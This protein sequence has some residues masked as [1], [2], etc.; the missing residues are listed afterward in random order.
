MCEFLC[1]CTFSFPLGINPGVE[2]L[3]HFVALNLIKPPDCAPK[4]RHNSSFPFVMHK[5]SGF[6][7]SLPTF[8]VF[9]LVVSSIPSFNLK[10]CIYILNV[11]AFCVLSCLVM[12]SSLRRHW[13]YS[14]LG[15]SVHGILQAW[16]REWVATSYS[17]IYSYIL[18][19]FLPKIILTLC[20]SD[21]TE[22]VTIT[23]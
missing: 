1:G 6:S 9:W 7:T 5:H 22:M 2:L 10:N 14:L 23:K 12:S 21:L 15:S 13:L 3:V 17:I 4:W 20:D 16:I 11:H 8:A 19:V 18:N